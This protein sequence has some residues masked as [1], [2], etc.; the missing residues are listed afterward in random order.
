M[1]KPLFT[2]NNWNF[3]LIQEIL[4][5]L[6]ELAQ[7]LKL[8]TYPNQI[9]IISSEQMLDAYASTGLPVM[10]RHW[11]FGKR[12]T[13]E[14]EQYQKGRSGLAYEIVLNTNPAIN[15]LMEENS[16]TMQTLVLAHAAFGHNHFFRNN[17][18]FQNT[19]ADSIIDYLVFARNY[20]DQCEEKHGSAAVEQT[21]DH[22]HALQTLGVDRARRPRRVSLAEEKIRQADRAAYLDSQISD[23][24]SR[25][26]PSRSQQVQDQEQKFPARP[27][28]NLLYFLEKHSPVLETWQREILRIV[29]KIS[30]YLQPQRETQV[31]NE[32]WASFVHY[33]LLNRLYDLGYLTEGS[34][35]EFL[36]S[37]TS[38]VFQPSFDSAYF[39]GRFNPYYLGFEI[40][41]DIQRRCQN[42][43]A[44]DLEYFPDQVNQP[45]L[46]TCL[47]AVENYRDESF[48]RQFFSPHLMRKM[49]LFQ[50]QD[51][52]QADHYVVSNI[53]DQRGF[54]NIRSALADSYELEYLT[55]K[56]EVVDADIKNT[57]KLTLNYY[58]QENRT[59]ASSYRVVLQHVQTLW[60]HTVE[61]N[62]VSGSE[63]RVLER[64]G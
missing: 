60:G 47:S 62:Q 64:C 44:E 7:E 53:H 26:V 14:R 39:S 45:W 41:R 49:R 27:E 59:L 46:D 19:P 31:M 38:V 1:N 63:S 40:F 9:E 10:Y 20:I 29:R 3:Q 12:F 55:P 52:R 48:I 34:M 25:T 51:D 22:A 13:R 8:K 33:Y 30:Q 57:R 61:L 50:L 15:Y 6:T 17:Y 18:L 28:E 4:E 2:G 11:S 21:L 36:K 37:H 5:V 56:I 54:R 42:P 35:L 16:A 43:S 24:W 58:Q 23:L 32:G